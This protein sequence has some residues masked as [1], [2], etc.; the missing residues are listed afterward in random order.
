MSNRTEKNLLT[1][2][3]V[4]NKYYGDFR[5]VDFS[6]DHTLVNERRFAYAVNMYKDYQSAQG[7]A[8]ETVPGFR[9]RLSDLGGRVYGIFPFALS[10][11]ES[12][13]VIH[14]GSSLLLWPMAGAPVSIY[15]GMNAHRSTSFVV[16]ERL[17][18]VDG[19]NYL[20]FDGREREGALRAEAVAS[21]AY[22]PTT[23]INATPAGEYA[24]GGT[25]YE[26]RN[27]LQ[28]RF[29]ETFRADGV[30]LTFYL[31]ENELDAVVS[32]LVDGAPVAFEA[33]AGEGSVTLGSPPED[34]CE[35]AVTAEKGASMFSGESGVEVIASCTV[36][37][38]FDNRVFL[39]G[40]P[41]HPN[42]IFWCARNS[43]GNVDPSYFGILNHQQ[44][45]TGSYPITGM[46]SV[47]DALMVLKR[48][49]RQDGSIYYHTAS[50]TGSDV[51]PVDYPSSRGLSGIGCLGACTSFIDDPVFVSE[52][53][54]EA[55]GQLSVRYE[56]SVEHRSSLIDAKLV[57]LGADKLAE[58]VLDE[59]NGYLL[60]LV[61]GKIFMADSRQQYTH[62][63][64]VTQYEWYYLEDIGVYS[65]ERREFAYAEALP[66][67]VR[68]VS[69]VGCEVALHPSAGSL[70]E[71][72][73]A[74][75]L[76]SF[77]IEGGAARPL[78]GEPE[79][80]ALVATCLVSAKEG[81][82]YLARETGAMTG[83]AFSPA[84][85]LAAFGGNIFFGTESGALCSFNFDMRDAE[86]VIPPEYYSFNGRTIFSGAATKMDNCGIPHLTKTTVKKSTVVKTKTLV[87]SSVK[88]KVRTNGAPYRQIG[89]ISVGKFNF[90]DLALDDLTFITD[91]ETIFAVKESER[92]WIEKQYFIYSDEFRK[93]FALFN[94]SYR[95]FVAG[96]VKK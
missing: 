19:K 45:G 47:A 7:E 36:A 78:E 52:R 43:T 20:W 44:D 3:D 6:S 76:K 34:G 10:S 85:A 84:C 14:A 15:E 17:Y 65:G 92:K 71:E 4:Y 42:H 27:V 81:K 88:I 91:D 62:D 75:E 29:R 31:S 49:A 22:V 95:Y 90:S 38:V 69:V 46:I 58:A 30:S 8:I 94:V 56:R 33:N 9:K 18:V 25:E 83:G 24:T 93:P 87:S 70:V 86:G 23:Y 53:G 48:G 68:G 13:L 26:Q 1:S 2:R 61:D 54:V 57:N 64:G 50:T 74:A 55:I 28:P 5:G 96:R 82:A 63:T 11:G 66:A 77:V 79:A 12:A 37:C 21:S 51:F 60:L 72:S 89:R 35:I 41:R 59:W 39:A 67:A 73:D 16:N 80:G 32:V 40:N